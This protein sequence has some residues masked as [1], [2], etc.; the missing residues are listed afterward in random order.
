MN[1]KSTPYAQILYY[2]RALLDYASIFGLNKTV[3]RAAYKFLMDMRS[4]VYKCDHVQY[5][6]LKIFLIPN[7]PGISTELKLFKVH[8]P[9]ST[10]I[11]KKQLRIGM[12]VMDIGS[13][14]GYYAL[15]AAKLVG[16]KGRVV[17]VEPNP[18]S[19]EYLTKNI[20]TN[21]LSNVVARNVA[22]WDKQ[23]FIDFIILKES[24]RCYVED[25]IIEN[26]VKMENMPLKY[27][28]KVPAITLDYLFDELYR[29][30]IIT[31]VDF[32]RMDV[33][34]GEWQIMKGARQVIEH[35]L[36][37]I[38][39]E[40][41]VPILGE[42]KSTGLLTALKEFGYNINCLILRQADIPIVCSYDDI[43]HNIEIE[44]LLQNISTFTK[45]PFLTLLLFLECPEKVFN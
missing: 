21:N 16:N 26:N 24:N 9:L 45:S 17:A 40:L 20:R 36:P 42:E 18:T 34:G 22:I 35:F 28:L 6:G 33:E 41:H 13:N 12:T 31:K 37:K 30:E 4:K 32:I 39:M 43:K 29:Q 14:I 23:D 38:F 15:M 44:S 7:D 3:K 5:D 11:L 25:A 27:R 10:S 8:E 1:I 2:V 19:Y